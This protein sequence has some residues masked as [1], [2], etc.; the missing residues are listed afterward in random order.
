MY[1]ASHEIPRSIRTHW[2]WPLNALRLSEVWAQFRVGLKESA[3]PLCLVFGLP[4]LLLVPG[5][6]YAGCDPWTTLQLPQNVQES[7]TWQGESVRGTAPDV[8]L[9]LHT[10]HGIL[11]ACW[12]SVVGVGSTV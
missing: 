7:P 6:S 12:G 4:M 11:K 9:Q 8:I 1:R 3:S 2:E 5:G 10:S